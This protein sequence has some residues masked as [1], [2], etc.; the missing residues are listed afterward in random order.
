MLYYHLPLFSDCKQPARITEQL[1]ITRFYV[2]Y[3]V[4]C[5]LSGI[6]NERG[7]KD[8]AHALEMPSLIATPSPT[9]SGNKYIP[10][11]TIHMLLLNGKGKQQVVLMCII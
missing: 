8:C 10:F 2:K 7:V 4:L 6:M 9:P 3:L 5:I 1:V 11:H